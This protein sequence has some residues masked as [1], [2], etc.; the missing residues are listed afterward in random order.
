MPKSLREIVAERIGKPLGW[1]ADREPDASW[2]RP[3]YHRPGDSLDKCG[4]GEVRITREQF[5]SDMRNRG[6]PLREAINVLNH[7]DLSDC[8]SMDSY[9][10]FLDTLQDRLGAK[11]PSSSS[12]TPSASSS[13]ASSSSSA[14][15]PQNPNRMRVCRVNG[16]PTLVIIKN[17]QYYDSK[18]GIIKGDVK[19]K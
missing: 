8:T 16:V 13:E 5:F 15:Q 3:S 14:Y 6:I 19:C 1:R 4:E 17:G 9:K 10:R 11:Q 18:G 7:S 12:D 2:H